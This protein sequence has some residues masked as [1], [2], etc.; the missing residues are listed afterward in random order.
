VGTGTLVHWYTMSEQCG[1]E[2]AGPA[3]PR[4]MPPS[5]NTINRRPCAQG[6]P[7]IPFHL[8]LNTFERYLPVVSQTEQL[9]LSFVWN[10]CK[11]RAFHSFPFSLT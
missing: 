6:L 11:A 2:W 3:S 5:T 4:V 10:E 8:N 7:L 1:K 9:K